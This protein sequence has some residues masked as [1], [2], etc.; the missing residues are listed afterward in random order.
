MHASVHPNM[1]DPDCATCKLR[2]VQIDPRATPNTRNDIAPEGTNGRNAWERGVVRDSRGMPYIDMDG[3][4]IS[5][6]RF[7]NNRSKFE[8]T[9]RQHQTVGA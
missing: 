5:T 7:A 6:K 3:T 2:S 9:L 8:A 1:D 4:P